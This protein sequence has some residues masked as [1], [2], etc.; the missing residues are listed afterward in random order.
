MNID[1]IEQGFVIELEIKKGDSKT[2]IKSAIATK[3]GDRIMLDPI[4]MDGKIVGFSDDVVVNMLYPINDSLFVWHDVKISPVKFEKNIYHAVTV[5][6]E[7]EKMNR[8]DSFR[9]YI[10]QK[11]TVTSFT[12]VGPES[13]EVLIKDISESGFAFIDT[14]PIK[15]GG[16]VRLTLEIEKSHYLCLT[17]KVVRSEERDRADM[18][19]GCKFME[20]NKILGEYLMRFQRDKAK[21]KNT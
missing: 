15:I 2:S 14:K 12:S 10:G 20:R 18:L 3:H 16:V 4:T 6:T 17:A 8:R 9:V 21:A 11:M 13:S 7:G 1:D 19:Y 5:D